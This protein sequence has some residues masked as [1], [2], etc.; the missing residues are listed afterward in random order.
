MNSYIV[1]MRGRNTPNIMKEA[2]ELFPEHKVVVICRDNDNLKEEGDIEPSLLINFLKESLSIQKHID[3]TSHIESNDS[4]WKLIVVS[5]GGTTQQLMGVVAACH[6]KLPT[7]FIE[8][9][10]G[11][12]IS[13]FLE[14]QII[15]YKNEMGEW[16]F[17]IS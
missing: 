8:I 15:Y 14:T 12:V 16:D 7:K 10:K 5:N 9:E 13:E 2:Q 1:I 4:G 3:F 6:G 11:G 17:F